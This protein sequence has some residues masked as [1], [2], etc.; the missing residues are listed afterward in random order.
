MIKFNETDYILFQFNKLLNAVL[1]HKILKNTR[2]LIQL[3]FK[4]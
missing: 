1:E 3:S 2:I 4:K